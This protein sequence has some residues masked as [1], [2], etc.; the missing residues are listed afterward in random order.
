MHVRVFIFR[1]TSSEQ[2]LY[3][4]LYFPLQK[5]PIQI[6]TYFHIT[7]FRNRKKKLIPFFKKSDISYRLLARFA[8]GREMYPRVT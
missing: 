7:Q 3:A 8:H 4:I 2:N 6:A 5:L 1:L